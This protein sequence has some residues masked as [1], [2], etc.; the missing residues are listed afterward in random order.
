MVDLGRDGG[1]GSEGLSRPMTALQNVA[2]HAIF[3]ALLRSEGVRS[4]LEIG[5]KAGGSIQ[6]VAAALPAGAR[7][8]AVDR[9][10]IAGDAEMAENRKQLNALFTLLEGLG[11]DAHLIL[12]NSH[13]DD[14]VAWVASFAPFDAV[15]ID[16]D[17]TLP[18][19]TQDW[20]NYGPMAKI[21]AFHD[22]GHSKPFSDRPAKIRVPEFWA[23]VK[24]SYRH[25]EIILE[26][27][28]N[29]IGVLWR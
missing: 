22:I 14:T 8:V 6:L 19:I 26:E 1:P 23:S 13:V 9:P 17:H 10:L 20:E 27:R 16:G 12:G 25:Q 2:E 3:S 28:N 4:Y 18:G 11:F 21:V 5:A 24:D 15:F 7:I 29:G